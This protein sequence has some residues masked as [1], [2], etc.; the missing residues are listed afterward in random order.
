MGT[1]EEAIRKQRELQKANILNSFYT[2]EEIQKGGKAALVGEI[3]N[4]NG[5]NYKKQL[6]GKWIEVSEHGMSKKD[7]EKELERIR[8]N[9]SKGH[10]SMS[11]QAG[12]GKLHANISKLSDKEHS[13]EDLGIKYD[14]TKKAEEID[15]EKARHGRYEDT[16][17]N[18]KL[19]R[20]GQEYGNAAKKPEQKVKQSSSSESNENKPSGGKSL[21][22]HAKKTSDEVLK[23]VLANKNAPEDLKNEAKNELTRRQGSEKKEYWFR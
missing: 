22:E 18:R 10:S 17:E 15:I 8:F 3:R 7:S 13:D 21:E 23:K 16:A 2:D 1:I 6:N 20:V 14:K 4:W 11:E 9:D 19:N 5:K 12:M